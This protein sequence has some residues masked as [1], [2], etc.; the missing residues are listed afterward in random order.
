L[1]GEDIFG[2]GWFFGAGLGDAWDRCLEF[3]LEC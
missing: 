1:R 2:A 3:V